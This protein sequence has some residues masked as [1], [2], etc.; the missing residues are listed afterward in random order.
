MVAGVLRFSFEF[1]DVIMVV[2]D[3]ILLVDLNVRLPG[4]IVIR[5]GKG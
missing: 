5:P 4:R 1:R 2:T 3:H